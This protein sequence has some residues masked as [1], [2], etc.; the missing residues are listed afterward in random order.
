MALS[1]PLSTN[2]LLLGDDSAMFILLRLADS[3]PFFDKVKTLSVSEKL[4]EFKS[5]QNLD[6]KSDVIY[7]FDEASDPEMVKF[8]DSDRFAMSTLYFSDFPDADLA[9]NQYEIFIKAKLA[10]GDLI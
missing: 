10:H 4:G 5:C 7:G 3:S 1:A 9:Q 8:F 6:R 2:I